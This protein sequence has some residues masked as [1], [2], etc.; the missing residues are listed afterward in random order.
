[1][2]E[3]PKHDLHVTTQALPPW[4]ASIESALARSR[5]ASAFR[6]LPLPNYLVTGFYGTLANPERSDFL[7]SCFAGRQDATERLRMSVRPAGELELS[8][9]AER[10]VSSAGGV[11]LSFL[12]AWAPS[13]RGEL[14]RGSRLVVRVELQDAEIRVLPSV[15]E[16]LAQQYAAAEVQPEERDALERCIAN[17]CDEKAP[18]PLV[19]TAKVLA[20]VPVVHV[21]VQ[22]DRRSAG[23]VRLASTAGF[24]MAQ[25][26]SAASALLIR[27]RDKLNVG[28]L[29]EPARP[30]FERAG[31]CEIVRRAV[32]RR[33]VTTNVRELGLRTL[34]GRDLPGVQAELTALRAAISNESVFSTD[35]QGSLLST[36]EALSLATRELT[37]ARPSGDV[38]TTVALLGRVLTV[39]TNDR[40]VQDTL[41]EVAQ[42]LQ[43]RLL[44]A[45]NAHAL[46]CAEP[47]WF[48]D[49]DG[50]GYGDK[51]VSRR[52][53]TAPH[54][55]VANALDCFDRNAN[56]HP[57]QTKHFTNHRG[58]GKFDYDCDSQEA[59][60]KDLLAGG[61]RVMTRFGIPIRCWAAMGWQVQVPACGKTGR[62]LADC[63]VSTFS[64]DVP[65]ERV[66]R[67]ACR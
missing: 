9:Q 33:R 49:S 46:P 50:D 24:E 37:A 17:L 63:E 32:V 15:P 36:L 41:L 53:P 67:Q 52:S 56:A 61:C 47:V 22:G 5:S 59:T 27:G 12:G 25:S 30:A 21:S 51:L 43:R 26:S 16:I 55:F 6:C 11:D 14:E 1:V 65:D 20:A 44:D 57:G 45:A 10:R 35:E 28:A 7:N 40:R 60:Q 29:L 64:C 38:C 13:I 66:E 31:T 48:Q 34:A 39:A 58:D 3:A 18:E 4:C 23:A 42:P 8:M 62:W 19:Y 2:E 54:G